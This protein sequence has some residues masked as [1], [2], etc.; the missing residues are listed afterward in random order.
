MNDLRTKSAREWAKKHNIQLSLFD[1][2]Y[3]KQIKA[4]KREKK[5]NKLKDK[6]KSKEICQGIRAESS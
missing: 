1:R 4:T 6:E 5:A 2:G 3:L